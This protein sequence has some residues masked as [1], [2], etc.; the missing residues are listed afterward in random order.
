MT[1]NMYYLLL[2]IYLVIYFILLR[3]LF[4]MKRSSCELKEIMKR[5]DQ[6]DA[7]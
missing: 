3:M 4:S 7:N 5:T 1:H 6:V 2:F